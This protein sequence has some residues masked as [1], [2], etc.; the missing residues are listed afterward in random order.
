MEYLGGNS[1]EQVSSVYLTR[2]DMPTYCNPDLKRPSELPYFLDN[3]LDVGRSLWDRKA[4]IAHLDIE[5]VNFDFPAEPYLDMARS[6]TLQEPVIL[7]IKKILAGYGLSFLHLVSGRGHHIVWQ[8]PK[9]SA[10]FTKLRRLPHSFTAATVNPKYC[11]AGLAEN[12]PDDFRQGFAGL[13]LAME[14]LALR[15]KAQDCQRS[16]LPVELT[17]VTAGPL[18][19]GREIISIDISEYGDPL[20]TRM[21][22]LPFSR[23][24]KPWVKDIGLDRQA[25]EK[26]PGILMVPENNLKIERI[27]AVMHDPEAA[28]GLAKETSTR[29]PAVTGAMERII[30]DYLRSELRKFHRW[31]YSQDHE[32]HEQWP[33]TYDLTQLELLPP[34]VARILRQPNDLLLIPANI[35]ILVRTMLALGWHPRHI[36]GLIRSKYER[37][38]GWGEY[39][40]TYDAGSRADLYT[41]IFSGPFVTGKD[42]LIDFNCVSTQEKQMCQT[43]NGQ[44]SLE[45]FTQSLLARRKYGRFASRPFNRLFLP[46][47]HI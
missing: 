30:K 32:P 4:L 16:D 26:M 43:P 42:D 24:L 25:L 47:E 10:A 1:L 31:F 15:I 41:R 2:C 12:V 22:R 44:C 29:I 45:P 3:F 20:Q 5:Y 38:F 18:K 33:A 11:C 27:I 21:I 37:D 6:F 14:F 17:A 34:C 8:I 9:P 7:A 19:R 36:A 46:A 13:G 40:L 28:A 23:Y 35:Q 39:W